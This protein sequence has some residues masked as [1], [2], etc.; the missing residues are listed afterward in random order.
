MYSTSIETMCYIL[1]PFQPL[2]KTRVYIM[3]VFFCLLLL[4]GIIYLAFHLSFAMQN[5]Q[6]TPQILCKH[7]LHLQYYNFQLNVGQKPQKT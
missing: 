2:C 1:S 3:H 7:I 4:Q 6:I 5:G